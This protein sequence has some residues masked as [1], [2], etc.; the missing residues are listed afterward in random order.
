[1]KLAFNRLIY[2]NTK[3]VISV[4]ELL[5]FKVAVQNNRVKK[6]HSHQHDCSTGDTR[7]NNQH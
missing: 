2:N 1:M 6:L 7:V 4:K 5:Y 3:I